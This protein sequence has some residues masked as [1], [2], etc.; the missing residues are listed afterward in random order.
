MGKY[1]PIN[2]KKKARQHVKKGNSLSA[3]QSN[4]ARACFGGGRRVRMTTTE[5][6]RVARAMNAIMRVVQPNP[7]GSMS[8][9]NVMGYMTEPGYMLVCHICTEGWMMRRWASRETY[10]H[11]RRQR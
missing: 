5:N 9:R 2:E 11:C 6:D 3:A 4:S 7:T 8:W 10:Q 1:R